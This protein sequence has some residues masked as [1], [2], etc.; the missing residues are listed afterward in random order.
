MYYAYRVDENRVYY[1]EKG[2]EGQLQQALIFIAMISPRTTMVPYGEMSR[3]S[4]LDLSLGRSDIR[5]RS[6]AIH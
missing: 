2:K 6:G 4:G 1:K 3:S 5:I